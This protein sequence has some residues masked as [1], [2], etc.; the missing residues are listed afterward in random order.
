ML[1]VFCERF[2]LERVG[3][4]VWICVHYKPLENCKFT[5]E[6]CRVLVDSASTQHPGTPAPPLGC[7]NDPLLGP[8]YT[9][10]PYSS[11]KAGDRD[12]TQIRQVQIFVTCLSSDSR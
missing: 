9:G 7:R 3:R 2:I 10:V 11:W 4:H 12:V 6:T 8:D 5:L 1:S